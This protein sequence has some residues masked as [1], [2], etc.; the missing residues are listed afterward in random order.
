MVLTNEKFRK[1]LE[2][3]RNGYT[4]QIDP[5]RGMVY[6]IDWEESPVL[7]LLVDLADCNVFKKE[8][9]ERVLKCRCGSFNI[10]YRE[11]CSRCDSTDL[12]KDGLIEHDGPGHIIPVSE[13]KKN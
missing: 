5:N 12:M 7:S 4:P 8:F 3:G 1:I 9:F 6:D 13:I 2:G 10:L 11:A